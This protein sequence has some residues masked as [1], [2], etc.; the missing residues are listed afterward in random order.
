MTAQVVFAY[1]SYINQNNQYA[2]RAAWSAL[3][4]LHAEMGRC[5]L[6][7]EPISEYGNSDPQGLFCG[8]DSSPL[9]NLKRGAGDRHRNTIHS[10][11]I[12]LEFEDSSERG[13]NRPCNLNKRGD[14]R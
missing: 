4:T 3:P 2:G 6:S 9:K 11:L 5:T 8:A 12:K 10:E 7:V 1:F 13:P 14:H